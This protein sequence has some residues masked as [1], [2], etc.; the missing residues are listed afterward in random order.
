MKKILISGVVVLT[1]I[2]GATSLYTVKK[3]ETISSEKIAEFNNDAANAMTGFPDAF[4]Q[5][6][7][8]NKR[9]FGLVFDEII[10]MNFKPDAEPLVIKNH[11]VS[12]PGFLKGNTNVENTGIATMVFEKIP[13]LETSHQFKWTYLPLFDKTHSDF[14]LAPMLIEL[15]GGVVDFKGFN[16]S[17]EQSGGVMGGSLSMK[18][19]EFTPLGGMTMAV[20][21]YSGDFNGEMKNGVWVDYDQNF[22]L[23]YVHSPFVNLENFTLV[24]D[25]V[26]I[27]EKANMNID[28]A[29]DQL[30]GMAESIAFALKGATFN[31]RLEGFDMNALQG[32]NQSKTPEE[33][34]A[35]LTGFFKDGLFYTLEN[36]S[37]EIQLTGAQFSGGSLSGWVAAEGTAQV[38]LPDDAT[39]EDDL[40]NHA[41]AEISLSADK[42]MMISFLG[43]QLQELIT[44]GLLV[45]EADSITSQLTVGDGLVAL[46]GKPVKQL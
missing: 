7:V 18:G 37:T 38:Q 26:T 39:L 33:V 10:T 43:P 11:V 24:S 1:A 42:N 15:E 36:F 45:E 35:T 12:F 19:L 17:G 40:K 21:R 27:D 14:E 44:Q 3:Y 46:N 25:Q 16:L 29:V 32:M 22:L 9:F 34:L 23:E 5:V 8:V 31:N 30:S 4:L 2:A 41:V 20:G 6:E 13:A 28:L